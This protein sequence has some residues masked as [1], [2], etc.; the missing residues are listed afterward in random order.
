[1]ELIRQIIS[2]PL[3][4]A[5]GWTVLHSFW[6]ALGIGLLLAVAHYLIRPQ[7]AEIRYYT[8]F[9]GLFLVLIA[10]VVTFFKVY[11]SPQPLAEETG[12]TVFIIGEPTD[13]TT[14]AEGWTNFAQQFSIYF[15]NHLPLIVSV[16]L[17]GVT[18]FILR[19][20][21]SLLQ[22]RLL[23][24]RH[25]QPLSDNWQS[26]L[27]ALRRKLGIIRP[28]GLLESAQIQVPMVLGYLKPVILLPV[29]AVNN[30][31]TEQVEAILAHE[32]AHILRNDYLLNIIQSLIE[33]LFYFNPAVWWISA[34]IRRERENCCDDI[35]VKLCGNSLTYAK[36][37]VELQELQQRVP[38]LAM[39]FSNGKNQ[40]L[41]RIR[42]ILNQPQ[43][44]S[45]VMEKFTATCML[46]VAVLLFSVG[47]GNAHKASAKSNAQEVFLTNPADALLEMDAEK[48]IVV[49]K[50]AGIKFESIVSEVNNAIEEID[51]TIEIDT[52]PDSKNRMRIKTTHEGQAVELDLKNGK[53][54]KL[55]ID[56]RSIPASEYT[57]YE[58]MVAD[59][60]ANIP[61]PPPPPPAPST[62]PEPPKPPRAVEPVTPPAPNTVPAPPA[63][64]VPPSAAEPG[65]PPPPPPPP[66]PKGMKEK[67]KNKVKIK[68]KD[69]TK[70]RI[71]QE[72][73]NYEN[74]K[75]IV[76]SGDETM[77]LIGDNG[78]VIELVA[79]SLEYVFHEELTQAEVERH[80][81][82]IERLRAEVAAKVNQERARVITQKEMVE[83]QAQLTAQQRE[84][85][86]QELQKKQA[87]LELV[88][89]QVHEEMKR[90]EIEMQ[91]QGNRFIIKNNSKGFAI[92]QSG[93][94]QA[95]FEEVLL[96]RGLLNDTG[97]Y[98]LEL[99]GN[100]LK[101]NGK[102]M[103]TDVW[104]A[105]KD[106][107]QEVH[108]DQINGKD[109]I[110]IDKKSKQK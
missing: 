94:M 65:V 110:V 36:A 35:A 13:I 39:T 97:N 51:V 86:Q 38:G 61:P 3:I 42:R 48:K 101:L 12:K 99:S 62:L 58:D 9:S 19:L 23:R 16:W 74:V 89:K 102:K 22:I 60:Q 52:I 11:E 31:T 90:Q 73:D 2:E 29:G 107:Y 72:D 26:K 54:Q 17:L 68:N 108:G 77:I 34:I 79:D 87:Q 71:L 76:L 69:K 96:D 41:Q 78:D 40:L 1:M 10:A 50:L 25:V 92:H 98:K 30:L 66:L 64:P 63:P 84:A 83:R 45:N 85:I 93:N 56:G 44:K 21:G 67:K 15:E 55:I 37:L 4:T 82:E 6:Q 106:I 103:P 95:R 46:L 27:K 7:S 59:I 75:E 49:E 47:A 18:F 8:A 33:I 5:L 57:K 91:R 109:K 70:I 20:L 81:A 24:T 80:R 53:I 14:P 32:L 104:Q 105:L 43:N 88:E 28:I 100:K